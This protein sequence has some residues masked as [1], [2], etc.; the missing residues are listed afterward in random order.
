MS[1]RECSNSS[2]TK[3]SCSGCAHAKGSGIPKEEL[4]SHSRIYNV[5]GIVSGKGGVGK[6]TVTSM[7][8]RKLAGAGY[9]VGIMDGDVTGPSIPK[10][11]G[12]KGVLDAEDNEIIPA[13]TSEGIKVVSMNLLLDDEEECV[14]YRGPVI[15]GIIKQFW[16][17][18]RWGELDYLLIDMPPGTGDVPLTVYQSLPVDGIVI[19]TSPQELVKMI[20]MKACDMAK[21]MNIRV[22]GMVENYSYFECPDCKKIVHIFGDSKV[23]EIA[24][25]LKVPVIAKLPV[26][27]D[28]AGLADRGE[29]APKEMDIDISFLGGRLES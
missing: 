17:D 25:E 11:F 21:K 12:L 28:M 20:V 5:I 9:R 14:V 4:N 1:D 13:V 23:D 16:S 26:L 18:V 19:V 27:P 22:L 3:E 29:S 15:A 7:I 24:E 10:M 2:C 6:S 8:A